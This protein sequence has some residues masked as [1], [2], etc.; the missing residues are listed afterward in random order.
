MSKAE[1]RTNEIIGEYHD[2]DWTDHSRH[3][4]MWHSFCQGYKQA[5]SD[6]IQE[7]DGILKWPP[8]ENEVKKV[9]R[10]EEVI[11]KYK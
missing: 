3:N 11:K 4:T 8:G 9:L 5:E 7:I 1:T 10:I 2:E 6:I